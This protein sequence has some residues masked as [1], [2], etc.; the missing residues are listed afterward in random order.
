MS[1]MTS[2]DQP[3]R[4]IRVGN[5]QMS[6]RETLDALEQNIIYAKDGAADLLRYLG[7]LPSSPEQAHVV[8]ELQR[9]QGYLGGVLLQ[10]VRALRDDHEE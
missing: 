5:A 4:R 9:I 2:P 6:R 3:D 10:L 8:H 7:R 1:T